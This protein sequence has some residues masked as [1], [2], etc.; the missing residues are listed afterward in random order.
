MNDISLL[1]LKSK[2]IL[3]ADDSTLSFAGS[4]PIQLKHDI[5]IDIKLI[6][7]WLASNRLIVN[8]LKTNFM[9]ISYSN[10]SKKLFNNFEDEFDNHK[11]ECVSEVKL[12][13]VI[14]DKSKLI[15]KSTL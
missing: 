4:D 7:D 10:V 12:L 8:W 5:L 1:A 13:G 15:A 14:I 9:I 11:L 3:F 6:S 2:L